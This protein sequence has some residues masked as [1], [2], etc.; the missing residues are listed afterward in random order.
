M[1]KTLH[2]AQ[3][4]FISLATLFFLSNSAWGVVDIS[5]QPLL[6][7]E[8]LAPNIVYIIDDSGSMNRD[9]LPD[10]SACSSSSGGDDENVVR[11]DTGRLNASK[12][13]RC[14][15]PDYN[16]LYY[17]P[18]ITY[19]APVN[20]AATTLGNSTYSGAWRNGYASTRS[21]QITDL[22]LWRRTSSQ[23]Y[24]GTAASTYDTYTSGF[25]CINA[26]R[27]GALYSYVLYNCSTATA[28]IP[29]TGYRLTNPDTIWRAASTTSIVNGTTGFIC[30]TT[31]SYSS[32]VSFYTQCANASTS[33][34]RTGTRLTSPTEVWL[35]TTVSSVTSAS[36]GYV[37]TGRTGPSSMYA[38]YDCGFAASGSTRTGYLINE[39]FY[40]YSHNGTGSKTSDSSYNKVSISTDAQRQNVAN[41]Y[42]YYRT[43]I[44]TAR[45]GTSLAFS[46]I[47]G[48]Y[49]VGYGKINS[50]S[51]ITSGVR[52][53][54]GIKSNFYDWLFAIA[55]DGNTPLRRALDR[56]GQYYESAEPWREDPSNSSSDELSCRQSF[57][58]LMTD[59]YWTTGSSAG[60]SGTAATNTDGADGELITSADSQNTYKYTP[61]SPFTDTYTGTLADVA[62]HYWKRDLRPTLA[63]DVPTSTTDP[64]FW[65]HMVTIG[66]G[67]GVEPSQVTKTNAFSAISTGATISW[68]NPSSSNP[69]R[70]DDLLH[71]AVNSRGDFYSAK[72]PTAF[73]DG[74]RQS[75]ASIQS[76]LGSGTSLSSNST[77]VE[78]GSAVFKASYQSV[79]W[80]G[81]LAAYTVST[82]GINSTAAWIASERLPTQANRSIFTRA[83]GTATTFIWANLSGTQQTALGS[84]NIVNYL[85]GDQSLE[86]ANGGTL[87]TRTNGPLGDIVNS[88]PYYVGVPDATLYASRT[89]TGASSHAAFAETNASRTKMVYVGANDGMLHGFNAEVAAT[90]ENRG[91]EVF[92]YIP[93]A[94]VNTNLASLA[95]P[96]YTHRYFVDG[97]ITVADAYI[98]SAWKSVLVATLGRGGKSVFAIDV[99]DPSSMSTNKMLWETTPSV[100]GQSPGKPTIARLADGNWMAIMGNGYNS[101]DNHARLVMINLQSGAVSSIDT[102]VGSSSSPNG[103]SAPYVID[104]DNDGNADRAY[105]GDIQGNLWRFDLAAQTATKI[106]QARDSSDNAQPI[107]SGVSVVK[108]TSTGDYWIYFGTGKFL[109]ESDIT[110]TSVQTWYGLTDGSEISDRSLLHQS[111]IV[112]N[113]ASSS[114]DYTVRTVSEVSAND[115]TGKRGWYMDLITGNTHTGERMILTNQIINGV[116][117]G[118]TLVPTGT[119]CNPNGDGFVMALN[120]FTGGRLD[121]N[122]FVY[123]GTVITGSGISFSSTPSNVVY[124]DGSLYTQLENTNVRKVGVNTP[125]GTTTRRKTWRELIG[126]EP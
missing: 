58:I 97:Q 22:R 3:L 50:D 45:A 28:D 80:S 124:K 105:A 121:Y 26:D 67:L 104:T 118:Q 81:D 23:T 106:F 24:T 72:D 69:A 12:S 103:L 125:S 96:S 115:L 34:P 120:L 39:E 6:V 60:A 102:S 25:V 48:S 30:S 14:Q 7:A 88:T 113:T 85:R 20:A 8:P 46:S 52:P 100:M 51:V 40:Y 110:T 83:G 35:A 119:Q 32:G 117:I 57:T 17:N 65:Q 56:A 21:T 108:R 95:S 92:A 71:A 123:N 55:P 18:N 90:V 2:E 91:K 53:Y 68:P 4:S 62:M 77:E 86:Q 59:G 116:L 111:S 76:R 101:S 79:I 99:T 93:E 43:R 82:N 122:Y 13:A 84:S 63:N 31:V 70:I 61:T 38:Y 37:C 78:D 15:S 54:S 89:W 11:M 29:I 36:S 41:W 94:L 19:T 64:A 47:S 66:L 10:S 73:T 87:R 112:S 74:L 49:R 42:S 9:D 16:Q 44:Y 109:G 98:G 126:V 1:K 107:T 27:T 5:T 33:S 114:G 75:L